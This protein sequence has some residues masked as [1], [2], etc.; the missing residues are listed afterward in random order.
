LP[1]EE[2]GGKSGEWCRELADRKALLFF[3]FS[4]FHHHRL[5]PCGGAPD[6]LVGI[7]RLDR[8][9]QAGA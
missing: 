6:E 5:D 3:F 1:I 2:T 7:A 9:G 4:S 8:E